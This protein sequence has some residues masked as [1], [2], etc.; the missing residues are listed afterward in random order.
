MASN[1][2]NARTNKNDE[3]YTRFDTINDEINTNEHGYRPFFKDQIVYCNCDDP[4]E[5]NF[6]KFFKA[7]FK[8]Y[9][10]KKLISTHYTQDGSS[11]YKLEYDGERVVKTELEGNGDFR[12]PECVELLK[13]S[14]IVVTNPPF[15]LFIPFV[16]L[17][18]QYN[19][20]FVIIGNKNAIPLKN[21]FKFI[22]E[23][24]IW[25]GYEIPKDFITPEGKITTRVNGLCRW[26][27]NLEIPK[28]REPLLIGWRYEKGLE[29][30]MY[31]KYE[32]YD[33]INVNE[34]CEIPKDYFGLMGV[35]ITFLDKFCPE[36]FEIVGCAEPATR[37]DV[38]KTQK[39]FKEYKSRQIY[40]DGIL[41]QKHYHRLL[42]RRI[43]K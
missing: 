35:P 2:N 21:V 33:A 24:K 34:V 4:E 1:L 6:W 36:Q 42:I 40:I 28:R 10:T 13:E 25:T 37:L 12:S 18:M 27:T 16:E 9:G 5:S 32:N 17:L 30:G 31:A 39:K 43:Q 15:S 19:K 8:A 41:C 3:F 7:V 14:D 26:F 23:G 38:L 11:S 20:K 29:M 22:K